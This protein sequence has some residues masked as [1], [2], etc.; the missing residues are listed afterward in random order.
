MQPARR[1]EQPVDF[2]PERGQGNRLRQV[3][4]EAGSEGF[5]AV[6]LHGA[7]GNRDNGS[8]QKPWVA[9]QFLEYFEASQLGHL[10]IKQDQV[11][12]VIFGLGQSVP[13][14]GSLDDL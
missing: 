5:L 10:Q 11:W 13:S 4:I 7:G 14:I 2:C 12:R 8:L 6:S 1:S 3:S 9:S